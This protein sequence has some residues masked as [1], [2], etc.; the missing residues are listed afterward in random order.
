MRWLQRLFLGYCMFILVLVWVLKRAKRLRNTDG[1]H[2]R[3]GG[4]RVTR[5]NRSRFF[6]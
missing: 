1:T 6:R 3:A 5:S 4:D 2:D